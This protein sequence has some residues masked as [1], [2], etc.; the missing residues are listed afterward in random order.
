MNKNLIIISIVII[1]VLI[2]I[3]FV[4]I[5]DE[6]ETFNCITTPCVMPKITIYESLQIQFPEINSFDE[7]L[8]AGNPAMESYPRQCMTT[9]GKHFVEQIDP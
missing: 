4:P 1:S 3:F 6:F 9:N 2:V 8:A 5:I 7:C